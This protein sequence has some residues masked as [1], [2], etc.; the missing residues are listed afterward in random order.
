MRKGYFIG[1]VSY[2]PTWTE[3]KLEGILDKRGFALGK[4]FE[5]IDQELGVF[6]R[7][8][9]LNSTIIYYAK[10]FDDVRLRNKYLKLFNPSI[11]TA[12]KTLP[13][14]FQ[15]D[16]HNKNITHEKAGIF[17]GDTNDPY[18]S[19]GI[20]KGLINHLNV[21]PE[22]SIHS[23]LEIIRAYVKRHTRKQ[24]LPPYYEEFETIL[25]ANLYH[26]RGL[27]QNLEPILRYMYFLK[28]D[29]LKRGSRLTKSQ[30]LFILLFESALEKIMR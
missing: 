21:E 3:K 29:M 26:D 27:T 23:F 22:R 24:K 19:V 17:L 12:D 1:T 13:Q 4:P 18:Y 15:S 9:K 10:D 25:S 20:K 11:E 7:E 5:V 8:A 28:N 6:E 2:H 14:K 30:F 16:F